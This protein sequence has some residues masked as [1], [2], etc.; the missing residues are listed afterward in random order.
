MADNEE[1]TK[2]ESPS[3]EEAEKVEFEVEEEK[4][5]APDPAPQGS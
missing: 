2:V 3:S 1:W 5:A 4:E